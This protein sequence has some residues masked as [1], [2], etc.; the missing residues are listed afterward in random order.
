MITNVPMTHDLYA[1]YEHQLSAHVSLAFEGS[2]VKMIPVGYWGDSVFTSDNSSL[3]DDTFDETGDSPVIY[4]T[5]YPLDSDNY[6]AV[7]NYTF[8]KINHAFLLLSEQLDKTDKTTRQEDDKYLNYECDH[9]MLVGL[10]NY[11]IVDNK[12]LSYRAYMSLSSDERNP[13]GFQAVTGK[14][15]ADSSWSH[16]PD[17]SIPHDLRNPLYWENYLNWYNNECSRKSIYYNC[18]N[19]YQICY[20]I[21]DHI[22]IHK[23]EN[24]NITFR[25]CKQCG[26]YFLVSPNLRK[27][28]SS[29][30]AEEGAVNKMK[31]WRQD[32]I[33]SESEQ[34]IDML[35]KRG[36]R[37][38]RPNAYKKEITEIQNTVKRCKNSIRSGEMTMEEAKQVLAKIKSIYA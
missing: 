31:R 38:G 24:S 37:V 22:I 6:M 17:E 9:A 20:S 2:I 15:I 36:S 12:S 14:Y 30:C 3:S 11:L 28:C 27:Y 23:A 34:I 29:A 21:F 19:L 4:D 16:T 25:Q 35:R 26:Q 18:D 1:N 8:E 10:Y 32:P 33:N 5:F 7:L 13:F